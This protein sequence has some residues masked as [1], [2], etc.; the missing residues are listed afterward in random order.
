MKLRTKATLFV[1]VCIIVACVAMAILSWHNANDSFDASL[2]LQTASNLKILKGDLEAR[3]DGDWHVE[4]GQLFRGTQNLS[5]ATDLVDT[6]GESSD[7]FVTFFVGDTRT[8]TNVKDA[9]GARSIG[10]KASGKVVD[11]VLKKGGSYTGHTTINGADYMAAYLPL[12]D[13]SGQ[14]VG[15]IFAGKA[16]SHMAGVKSDFMAKAL[17]STLI[18]VLVLIAVLGVLSYV[19]IGRAL[20]PLV[21]LTEV[22]QK[23]ADGDLTNKLSATDRADEVGMLQNSSSKMMKSLRDMVK[24]TAQAS[25]QVSAS[26]EELTASANQTAQAS[27][28]AAESVVSIAEQSAEQSGIVEETTKKVEGVN[29][30]MKSVSKAL[31]TAKDAVDAAQHATEEGD[32][33]L[34]AAIDGIEEIARG[35]VESGEAVQKLYEGSKNIA[36][37]NKVITD[38]A[39]QT[40][41]LALNAA[42]EA[43]RAGEQGRGFAVVAD[44]VRKLAEESESA[45]Q[46]IGGVIQTN[47]EEIERTFALAK[48]QQ[49]EVHGGV[50]QAKAAGEKFH[51][52]MQRIA[53]LNTEIAHIASIGETIQ[54]ECVETVKGVARVSEVAHNVQKKATDVS[55]VS[56]EQAAST[57]EIA[58]ASHTL[59]ELAEK[60][61]AGVQKFRL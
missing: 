3:F 41:L 45:A 43:A 35:S 18:T 19:G 25:E 32:R 53:D 50:A 40:K 30:R 42:I 55:A 49:D 14:N 12:T 2:Q 38:I 28:S 22:L 58:A 7:G 34:D 6:L 57:E 17:V 20:Q 48:K 4:S 44:E 16:I 23:I 21:Y 5:E 31:V 61:Q 59:A 33:V 27:Q 10:S 51:D 9:Q 8:M 39:G 46:E 24:N 56:E 52:I 26:S 60:L 1:N 47:S 13:A 29:E 15:M 37:I 11:A 36:E 54:K